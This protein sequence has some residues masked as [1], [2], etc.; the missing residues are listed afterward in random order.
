MVEPVIVSEPVVV[1]EPITIEAVSV[2]EPIAVE[3]VSEVPAQV[4]TSDVVVEVETPAD[5]TPKA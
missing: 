5:E 1:S 4:T 3:A 2:S